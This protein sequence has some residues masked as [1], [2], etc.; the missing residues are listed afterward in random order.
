MAQGLG[1]IHRRI[2]RF[3]R[4]LGL[5]AALPLFWACLDRTLTPPDNHPSTTVTNKQ[6]ATLENKLDILFMIDDSPSMAPLQQKLLDQFPVFMNRLKMIPA[7]DGNGTALPN[8]HVAVVSSDTGPGQFLTTPGC[9]FEGDHGQFQFQPTGTCTTP[10]LHATPTQQT[11]LSA[12]KNQAVKNYDG[13]I[14]DAFKCIAALGQKGCGFEGQLKSVRWALDPSNVPAGNE[15]FLR[16]D[17]FLAVILITNEDDCSVPDTS[18]LVD[19]TQTLMSDPLGPYWSFRCNEFG[20]LCMINGT[21][22]PPPRGAADNLQGCTSNETDSGRLTKVRDEVAFLRSLKTDP[23]NQIFVAA[24]TGLPTSYGI[25]MIKLDGD[26]EPHPNMKHSCTNGAEYADPAV[27]IKNWVDS[28]GDHGLI[29]TICADNFRDSLSAIADGVGVLVKPQCIKGTLV[30]RDPT[31]PALEPECQVSDTFVDAQ[32]HTHEAAVH[33]C[34][35]NPTPPC[36]SLD[37]SAMCTTGGRLL[38]VTRGPDGA[39]D[40]L[41]TTISCATCIA[42]VAHAGCACVAGKEVDGC[43][44]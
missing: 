15:G 1:L 34:A 7:P 17:A 38:N 13:D 40:G 14:S 21:L 6:P 8:I 43:L 29:Q 9:H 36:W 32:N 41:T 35:Q 12:A 39:P 20:H 33:A 2:Y 30:D 26:V 5:A 25:A 24:I 11:F 23:D 44:H 22:Q 16:S 42:G 27:R 3:T 37:D 31:T 28:F 19:P 4:W 18:D 10:P